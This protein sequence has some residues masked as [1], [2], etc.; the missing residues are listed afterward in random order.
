MSAP[1]RRRRQPSGSLGRVELSLGAGVA[2]GG[3]G[4]GRLADGRVVFVEGGLPGERVA[5]ALTESHKDYAKGRL[6]AV[7]EASPD[8]V[9]P[10]CPWVERGCGGCGWQHVRPASQVA[11]KEKV[12]LD[13]LRRIAHLDAAEQLGPAVRLPFE[14]YRT[15]VH[16][17]VDDQG[18]PAYR[19]RH[20]H[21]LVAVSGCLVVHPRLGELIDGVRAPGADR[22]TLRVGVAGGERLVMPESPKT[23]AQ[24]ASAPTTVSAPPDALIVQAGDEAAFHEE[25]GGRRWRVSGRSF[26]QAG[27]EAAE[28][29]AGLVDEAV[30]SMVPGERLVDLYAGVGVLGG[31]VASRRPGIGLTAVESDPSAV[32]DAEA[33]LADLKAT[34]VAREVGDWAA[35][36]AQAVIADPAR[37]GLGRPGVRTVLATGCRRL[38]LV[39]CDP[40]SLARDVSLLAA[41]GGLLRTLRV[42]DLFPHTP[43]VETVAVVDFG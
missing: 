11:M 42:V 33:N 37:P 12:V 22:V 13:A 39:S 35:T 26:F 20:R 2:A 40:A 10:P 21:D 25:V 8:R 36:P 16:L 6:A 38:V 43:H 18:R 19:V 30:G 31:V 1:T 9:A 32:R 24:T 5:V 14:R 15:S 23:T 3:D 28:T 7:I 29:L 4:I 27:P 17:G 41:G 34:V